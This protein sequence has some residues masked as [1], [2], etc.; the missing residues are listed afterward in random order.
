MTQ[1]SNMELFD[2]LT[3]TKDREESIKIAM[4]LFPE[5]TREEAAAITDEALA[6]YHAA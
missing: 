6:G 3:E 2:R 5:M 4:Q 1:E